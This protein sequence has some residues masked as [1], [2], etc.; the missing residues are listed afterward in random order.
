LL[1]GKTQVILGNHARV[2][3]KHGNFLVVLQFGLEFLIFLMCFA[4]SYVAWQIYVRNRE[5]A[6]MAM[7]LVFP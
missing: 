7:L 4:I 1:S 6:M 3:N 5:L 2:I